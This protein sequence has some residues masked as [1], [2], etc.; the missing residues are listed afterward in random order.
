MLARIARLEPFAQVPAARMVEAARQ[1]FF[2]RFQDGDVLSE[3]GQPNDTLYLLLDGAAVF[4]LPGDP[5]SVG[6]AAA[7]EPV[8]EL[9]AMLGGVQM[10]SSVARGGATTVAIPGPLVRSLCRDV[11]TFREWLLPRARSRAFATV[12]RHS[13]A[14][15]KLESGTRNAIQSSLTQLEAEPGKLFTT[16]HEPVDALYLVAG[17]EVDVYGGTQ[18]ARRTHVA[19]VGDVFGI[20]CLPSIA[21]PA[22]LSARARGQAFIAMI[23]KARLHEIA[24]MHPDLATLARADGVLF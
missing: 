1:C 16:E 7:G 3:S 18:G 22:S 8:G 21:T 15:R 17:G 10:T 19:R 4:K 23:P 14:L 12:A 9:A 6:S 2:A 13:V 11:P 5:M 24:R 20:G